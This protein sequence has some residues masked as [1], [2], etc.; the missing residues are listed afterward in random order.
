MTVR[1]L[2]SAQLF[3]TVLILNSCNPAFFGGRLKSDYDEFMKSKNLLLPQIN[4]VLLRTCSC[5]I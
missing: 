1:L 3:V 2:L 4:P 5:Y